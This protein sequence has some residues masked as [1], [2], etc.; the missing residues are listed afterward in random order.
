MKTRSTCAAAVQYPRELT[1]ET[2]CPDG[3]AFDMTFISFQGE[4]KGSGSSDKSAVFFPV[5]V[6]RYLIA[7]NSSKILLENYAPILVRIREIRQE[8]SRF[9][10]ACSNEVLG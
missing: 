7:E 1:A 9:K 3:K 10:V 4:T 6:S 8:E 5:F 2:L